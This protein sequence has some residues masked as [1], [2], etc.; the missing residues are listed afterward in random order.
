M[1]IS[2]FY[3]I[4]YNKSS[5]KFKYAI[6]IWYSIYYYFYVITYIRNIYTYY[7]YKRIQ[8]RDRKYFIIT[9]HNSI[10][11]LLLECPKNGIGYGD[12]PWNA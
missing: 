11:I 10:Q 7:L 9:C 2:N 1:M 4:V 8:A 5:K 3:D 6:Y 12:N